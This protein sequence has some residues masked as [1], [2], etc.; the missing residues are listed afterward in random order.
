MIV[1]E[2]RRCKEIVSSL[3]D[4]A[5]QNQ[6]EAQPTDL[7]ALIETLVEVEHKRQRAP[8]IEIRLELDPA[9]PIIQA[10]PTQIQEVMTNLVSNSLEAMP[11]GGRLTIRTRRGPGQMVTIEVADTGIGIADQRAQ[12]GGARHHL[13][14]ST[15]GHP[16][17]DG[18][19]R[20][21]G[22][23]RDPD[24]LNRRGTGKA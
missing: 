24:R 3:L 2:T 18:R 13:R 10:D 8:H 20:A 19:S 7:N 12:P 6:V 22:H 11:N 1:N 16:A 17:A 21:A 23:T 5:R 4:F 15:A 9:L 14:D